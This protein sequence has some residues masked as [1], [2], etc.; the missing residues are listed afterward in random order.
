MALWLAIKVQFTW[1]H[2][3]VKITFSSQIKCTEKQIKEAKNVTEL[4]W[5]GQLTYF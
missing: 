3:V 1:C 2:A 5:Y 4:E